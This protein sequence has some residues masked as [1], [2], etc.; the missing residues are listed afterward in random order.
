[1][2]ISKA[3]K[4]IEFDRYSKASKG[5]EIAFLDTLN[6]FEGWEAALPSKGSWISYNDVDFTGLNNS[7]MIA[8]VMAHENTEF[9]IREGSAKGKV[10]AKGKIVCKT[11]GVRP[12]DYSGR[13]MNVTASVQYIPKGVVDLYFCCDGAA[14]HVDWV[15]F[16]NR[17]KYYSPAAATA[18]KPDADGFIRRWLVLE[19]IN[20]PNPTNTVFT[21][22]YLRDAFGKEYYKGQFT[23]VPVLNE[24]TGKYEGTLANDDLL[25]ELNRH[26]SL[27]IA[28]A[29]DRPLRSVSRRRDYSAVR[30]DAD[31]EDLLVSATSQNFVPVVDDTG[32]FIGIITRREVMRYLRDHMMVDENEFK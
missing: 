6:T 7:Y 22:S 9:T 31:M 10:I 8:N 1:V 32:C 27:T 28:A 15:Q 16:K 26:P 30:A 12:R 13:W 23:T 20:K 11:E 21:D 4:R 29:A 3:T 17:E 24:V 19:P 14:V 18:A 25:R 2:G 5:V